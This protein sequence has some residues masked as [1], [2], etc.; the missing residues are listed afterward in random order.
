MRRYKAVSEN[1][2]DDFKAELRRFI[3][4]GIANLQQDDIR[5]RHWSVAGGLLA[6]LSA[7]N[8]YDQCLRRTNLATLNASTLL[9]LHAFSYDNASRLQTVTDNT[10]ATPYSATYGYLAN[11]PLVS[12]ITFK[13]NTVPRILPWS[14]KLPLSPTRCR[15]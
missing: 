5:G 13:S 6:G 3:C 7:T 4:Q 15:A 1:L 2:A 11:S 10:T 8:G 9:T 14:A 12:Q